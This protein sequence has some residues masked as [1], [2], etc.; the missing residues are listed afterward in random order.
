MINKYGLYNVNGE[1]N[2][3]I[4]NFKYS[5]DGILQSFTPCP[6]GNKNGNRLSFTVM[7]VTLFCNPSHQIKSCSLNTSLF[8]SFFFIFPMIKIIYLW[9]ILSW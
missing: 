8:R 4:Q 2:E 1:N 6:R 9:E 7:I 5:Y 3:P